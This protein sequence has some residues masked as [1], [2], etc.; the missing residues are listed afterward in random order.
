[1]C[2]VTESKECGR[3]ILGIEKKVNDLVENMNE[4]KTELAVF[5]EGFSGLKAS[6]DRLVKKHETEAAEENVTLKK[7][8]R[9]KE[10]L[11]ETKKW[12]VKLLAIAAIFSF[13]SSLAMFVI[14]LK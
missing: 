1:M 5:K 7:E 2:E 14:S 3:A 12:Q 13:I 4:T 8:L 9:E 10:I 11:A 6:L